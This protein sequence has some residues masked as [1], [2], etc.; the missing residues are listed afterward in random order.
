MSTVIRVD[1]VSKLY[2]RMAPGYHLRTLK[3]ALLDGSLTAGLR[4]EETIPALRDVS[5]TVERGEAFGV[6]GSNGSGKSTLLKILSGILRPSSGTVEV[7]GRVAALI[8]LGAGFHPEISGRENIYINGVV[9]GL[10]RREIDRRFDEIVEFSGLAN[11]IEEPVKNYSSGMYVRL[12][13]SVAI[14]TDP[15]LLLVDEVL[16]VGDEAFSHR[17]L[18]R[19]EEFLA[20]GRTVLLVSHSLGLIEEFCTRA[21]WLDG[22]EK[23]LLGSPRRVADSYRQAVAEEEGR[24][25]RRAKEARES[26]LGQKEAVRPAEGEAPAAPTPQDEEPPEEEGAIL[27]WGSRQAEIV[28]AR[29]LGADGV[30]RYHFVSGE[31]VTFEIDVEAHEALSNVVFGVGIFTPRGVECWGTNT[32][33]EGFVSARLEGRATARVTCPNLRLAP[34]EYLL[35]AAVH[36]RDGNPYDYHRRIL[37]FTV[38]SQSG[39]VGVYYPEHEWSFGGGITWQAQPE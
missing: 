14:H 33:I 30:E 29:S 20:R 36:A 9:L 3:S 21:L 5:F 27:R 7:A 4:P 15:D 34:G 38:T 10:S 13:F 23:R 39:G 32:H 11:F 6:I 12:G 1:G 25:H 28:G 26:E 17:C 16:A 2:R 8:E 35:D 19:I 37:T 24:E 22:G 31:R 18:R